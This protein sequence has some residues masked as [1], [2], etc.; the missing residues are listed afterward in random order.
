MNSSTRTPWSVSRHIVCQA[1]LED[2]LKTLEGMEYVL[3]ATPPETSLWLHMVERIAKV[4]ALVH[5]Y[6]DNLI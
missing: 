5:K 4:K 6:E 2:A 3:K 1:D